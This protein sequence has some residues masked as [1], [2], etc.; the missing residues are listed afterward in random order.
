MSKK[1]IEVFQ[2]LLLHTKS[3]DLGS[4]RTALVKN[5]TAE[6][7]H[8][9]GSEAELLKYSGSKEDIIQFVHDSNGLPRAGLTLWERE[10]GYAVTN[11]VP[12]EKSELSVI[13]YN[14]L[15]Q[16]F[17]RQVVQPAQTEAGFFVKITGSVRG[18]DTWISKESAVLLQRFS[19]LANKSTTNSHPSDGKRWEQ[20]VISVHLEGAR[21]GTDILI[22]WL[23]EIDGWDERSSSK[24]AID[25]EKGL[26]LLAT[27]DSFAKG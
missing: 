18:L 10:S 17:V 8:S 4:I 13:E 6:W 7:Q 11:I 27:Y 15:L 1:G 24:L 25:Y 22:Q 19:A 14:A 12:A 9:A 3:G 16:D 2:D 5:Q 26:S 23:I 20:F 21:L